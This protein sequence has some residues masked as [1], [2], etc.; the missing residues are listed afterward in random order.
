MPG[1]F[2]ADPTGGATVIFGFVV[3]G[4]PVPQGSMRAFLP[5]GTKRP[6]VVHGKPKELSSWRHDIQH[7]A[8]RSAKE[9]GLLS[10]TSGP[11]EVY[12]RFYLRVPKSLPKTKKKRP[13]KRPDIDKLARSALDALTGVI[14]EDDSQVC[15]L[16]ATKSYAGRFED[17]TGPGGQPRLVAMFDLTPGEK[18]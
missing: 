7:E 11:V 18:S 16:A 3:R 10:P 9:V 12:L 4:I 2:R 13:T 5:K 17:P 8:A 14:F 1:V 15:K 6:V